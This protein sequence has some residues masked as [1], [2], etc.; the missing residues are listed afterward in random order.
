M[1]EKLENSPDSEK[2][3][4]MLQNLESRIVDLQSQL[5]AVRDQIA[6]GVLADKQSP[7]GKAMNVPYAAPAPFRG[8]GGYRG[9]RGGRGYGYIPP[10][11]GG[12]ADRGFNKA[13][14]AGGRNPFATDATQGASSPNGDGGEEANEAEN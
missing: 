3:P 6:A 9:G 12:Y 13:Y 11:R 14:V 2:K 10:A 7:P 5:R 8:G 4:Q 1:T